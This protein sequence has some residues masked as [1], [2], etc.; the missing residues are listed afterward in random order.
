MV[1]AGVNFKRE[2]VHNERDKVTV[3][4]RKGYDTDNQFLE[5]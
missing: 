2:M 1:D 3:R 4:L 5:L